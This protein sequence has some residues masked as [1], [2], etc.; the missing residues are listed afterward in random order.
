M[1][2]P[3]ASEGVELDLNTDVYNLGFDDWMEETDP[4]RPI[5][6]P[7][8]DAVLKKRMNVSKSFQEDLK[9]LSV[10]NQQELRNKPYKAH[11]RV[12]LRDRITSGWGLESQL[13]IQSN[14]NHF[15]RRTRRAIQ[16]V[17]C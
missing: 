7:Y 8:V 2:L 16:S 13:K 5:I 4:R 17:H 9:P 3:Y 14:G 1:R 15:E 10:N 11:N 12:N 6:K